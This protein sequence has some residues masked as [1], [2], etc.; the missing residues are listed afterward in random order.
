MILFLLENSHVPLTSVLLPA[1]EASAKWHVPMG[2]QQE[3]KKKEG[4]WY[5][6]F[7]SLPGTGSQGDKFSTTLPQAASFCL[8]G[9]NDN[10]NHCAYL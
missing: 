10:D 7:H 5:F 4:P 1:P 2:F 6:F 9:S 8:F 3:G